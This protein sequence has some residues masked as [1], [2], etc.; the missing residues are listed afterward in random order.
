VSVVA[1]SAAAQCP[2]PGPG[3]GPE[4]ARVDQQPGAR[5][6]PCSATQPHTHHQGTLPQP[7]LH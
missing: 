3:G 6:Q 2:D 4:E 5:V 1:A 7:P